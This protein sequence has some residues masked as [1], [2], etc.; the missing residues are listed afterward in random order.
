MIESHRI[1]RARST[2]QAVYLMRTH[3][4]RKMEWRLLGGR[5]HLEEQEKERK[6]D[7]A[8]NNLWRREITRFAHILEVHRVYPFLSL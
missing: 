5:T 3:E 1:L 6:I 4:S 8:R 2:A 7:E